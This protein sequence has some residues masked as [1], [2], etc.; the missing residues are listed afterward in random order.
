MAPTL[1]C[2]VGWEER[3][4]VQVR[5]GG[6]GRSGPRRSRDRGQGW[7]AVLR[8]S[9]EQGEARPV[10]P[11]LVCQG[12]AST[13][14]RCVQSATSWAWASVHSA[15]KWGGRGAQGETDPLPTHSYTGTHTPTSWGR[16]VGLVAW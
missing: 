10:T 13:P 14:L 4:R 12:L 6:S 5:G 2:P 1:R 7:A 16:A 3:D 8:R 15:L 11:P 9:Q